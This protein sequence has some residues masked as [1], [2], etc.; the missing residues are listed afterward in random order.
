[1][2]PIIGAKGRTGNVTEI[3]IPEKSAGGAAAG[4]LDAEALKQLMGYLG[5]KDING[6]TPANTNPTMSDVT[7]PV[8]R[9]AQG[10][11]AQQLAVIVNRAD[12]QANTLQSL[13]AAIAALKTDPSPVGTII[14]SVLTT[15]QFQAKYGT[16]SANATWVYADGRDVTGSV[17]AQVTGRTTVPDLR[18]AYLRHAGTNANGW[19]GGAVNVFN[20]DATRL[21]RYTGFTAT[22]NDPRTN[23]GNTRGLSGSSAF[24]AGEAYLNPGTSTVQITGGDTETRPKSYTVNPYIRIN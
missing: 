2:D 13:T 19:A 1:M 23:S 24:A 8:P 9:L 21:P 3:N 20:E 12:S 4:S 6:F 16:F 5:G 17:Y 18:G 22:V 7:T 15:V 14:P 11:V 10:A